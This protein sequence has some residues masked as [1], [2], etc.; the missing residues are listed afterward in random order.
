MPD[1]Q[2]FMPLLQPRDL[3]S[4]MGN[5]ILPGKTED[6][7]LLLRKFLEVPQHSR[8]L[9]PNREEKEKGRFC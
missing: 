6:D 2:S 5:M 1:Y 3:E 4:D 9:P 8:H 7:Q